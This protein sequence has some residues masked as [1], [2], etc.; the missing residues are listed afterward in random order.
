MKSEA[1]STKSKKRQQQ[2]Y[3]IYIDIGC[4]LGGYQYSLA[5]SGGDNGQSALITLECDTSQSREVFKM[6]S[7]KMDE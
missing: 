7:K 6:W 1:D 5:L 4:F 3:N 2:K